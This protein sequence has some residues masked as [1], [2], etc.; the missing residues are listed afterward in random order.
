MPSPIPLAPATDKYGGR[1][2]QIYYTHR[3]N[4]PFSISNIIKFFYKLTLNDYKEFLRNLNLKSCRACT[5]PT[6][7][8]SVQIYTMSKNKLI[9][10]MTNLRH[11]QVEHIPAPVE[12]TTVG[13]GN[14]LEHLTTAHGFVRP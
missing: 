4:T 6:R 14:S 1:L 9:N 5:A 3:F 7:E 12:G 11:S 13:N 10:T 8:E 2:G